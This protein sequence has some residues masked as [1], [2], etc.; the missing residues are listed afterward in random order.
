MTGCGYFRLIW[1]AQV[2][3][4]QGHE[5]F[6]MEP[7]NRSFTGRVEDDVLVD[8]KV[9]TDA[10]VIILQRVTHRHIAESI[11]I[12]RAKGVGVVVDIDDDLSTIHPRHP[13]FINLHPSK[14][15]DKVRNKT[16]L[17]HSWHNTAVA[18]RDASVVTTSSDALLTRYAKHG[19]GF[20]IRNYLPQHYLDVAHED[21]DVFG[22]GGAVQSHPDDLDIV[23]WSIRRLMKEDHKFKMVG[24]AWGVADALGVS[25]EI[26]ATGPISIE[27]WPKTLTQL[28]IG[29]APLRSNKFNEAKS[30]LKPLEYAGLGIPCVMS[31][32]HEYREIHR[33]GIGLIAEKPDKWY[34][35]LKKLLT[36][37]PYR[38]EFGE[39]SREIAATLT[40]A[41]QSWRWV[42]A[43]TQAAL[44]P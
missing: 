9:P 39:T 30:W 1:P 5:V 6:I 28:G 16:A 34:K 7:D 35:M 38:R 23:G 32:R 20:V 26:D 8:V 24:P 31:G 18:C 40:I 10:N 19:R 41:K 12:M 13:A 29:I 3:R 27:D 11:P 43:W 22:W 42:E 25:E 17:Y 14:N 33:Q 15:P 37:E 44:V 21:S 36:D 2:L 4:A